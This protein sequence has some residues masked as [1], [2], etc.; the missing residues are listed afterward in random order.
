MFSMISGLID[1]LQAKF[2][3]NRVV[4]LLTPFVTA[5]VAA[6]AAWLSQHFPGLPQPD[7]ATELGFAIAGASAV[8]AAAYKWLDGW[9][10]DEIAKTHAR[11]ERGESG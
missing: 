7:Q 4:A 2:P 8:I 11:I 5:G 6:G 1:K 3:P 9:Q 10:K